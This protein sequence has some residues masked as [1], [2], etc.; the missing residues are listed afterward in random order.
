MTCRI[1]RRHNGLVTWP[2]DIIEKKKQ[3]LK[4]LYADCI[5]EWL[6]QNFNCHESTIR[7]YQNR[8]GTANGHVMQKQWVLVVVKTTS[9]VWSLKH[10]TTYQKR[11][12]GVIQAIRSHAKN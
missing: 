9:T 12:F 1:R 4:L 6:F 5:C 8:K 10:R 7:H 2:I 3:I 11:Q